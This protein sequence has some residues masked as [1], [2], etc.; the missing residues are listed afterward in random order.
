MILI[1]TSAWIEFL[2]D[3][4]SATCEAVDHALSGDIA[5]CDPIAME[6]LAGA[7]DE[8]HLLSLRGLIA[9]AVIRPTT[10]ASYE[11]A[12]RLYRRCRASGGT[13]R[14]LF[15]CLIGA[16]ALEADVPILHA[17]RDFTVLAQH[18]ELHMAPGS[19]GSDTR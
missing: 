14:K 13:V 17:H 16:V 7:R 9:R 8:S 19:L 11:H 4:G 18:T 10:P 5:T 15:D 3:T 6:L 1:D 12:A 2:R